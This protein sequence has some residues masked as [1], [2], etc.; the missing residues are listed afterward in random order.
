MK[1]QRIA[2]WQSLPLLLSAQ[3]LRR[4]SLINRA[5]LDILAD[6]QFHSGEEIGAALGISRAAVWKQLQK[7]EAV[8]VP[9]ESIKGRGYC[10]PGGL[11]L[12]DPSAVKAA[13]PQGAAGLAD[14]LTIVPSV[15]ST[16][17]LASQALENGS[18]HGASFVAEHQSA[19]RGRRGRQWLSPFAR[20]LYLTT[21]W[22][23]T[24][25]AAALEC[26]SLSVAVAVARAL[27]RYGI[28]GLALKWP[29][30]VLAGDKK[31]AGI[32]LEMQG[33]P[34]GLCQVLVG[35]GLN[36]DLR[37]CQTDSIERPWVDL[38]SV[39]DVE[40]ERNELLA[41]LL[42]EL[43]TVYREFAGGGFGVHR[44]EWLALDA[45]KDTPVSIQLGEEWVNG[46]ARGVDAGGGLMLDVDGVNRTFYG[47]EVSLRAGR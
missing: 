10:V 38:R 27:R 19:G 46:I 3:W 22:E 18:G 23:F 5:L 21:I 6:G 4:R 20:S 37:G 45:Y 17:S 31:L 33:D 35:I 30:D 47:G 34:A 28:D 16:N 36:V 40:P 41:K 12:L 8:D 7:L 9:L 32:L 39:A 1:E 15:D 24:N 14:Q 29:N 25:G 44:D 42:V 43:A 26:L 11:N 13:L 2:R